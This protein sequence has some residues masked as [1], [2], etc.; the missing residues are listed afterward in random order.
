MGFNFK[1]P[2]NKGRFFWTAHSIDKMRFY[3]LSESKVINVINRPNRKEA[4]IAP[5]TIAV[6]QK[7]K[8]KRPTEIWVMYQNKKLKIK[9]GDSKLEIKGL[10][11][12][13]ISLTQ[14]KIISAWRYPGISP[15]KGKI[16]I[17]QDIL[18][19]LENLI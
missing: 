16:P 13:P 12:R 6:M 5:K 3:G 15:V 11:L 9:D 8:T 1:I 4:G 2:K 7:V 10:R 19:N 17:P 18:D 14:I